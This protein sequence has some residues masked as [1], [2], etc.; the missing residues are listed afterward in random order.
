MCC[1][2]HDSPSQNL[3]HVSE[4]LRLII[5]LETTSDPFQAQIFHASNTFEQLKIIKK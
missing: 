2:T 1:D 4:Q 5:F 3:L